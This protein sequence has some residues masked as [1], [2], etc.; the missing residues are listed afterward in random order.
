ME[1]LKSEDF[2][3]EGVNH[4]N[5]KWS[6]RKSISESHVNTYYLASQLRS[7]LKRYYYRYYGRWG[8]LNIKELNKDDR[9]EEVASGSNKAKDVW[10]SV[11]TH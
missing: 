1:R 9:E 7:Q 10:K 6:W 11:Q 4:W 8:I 2:Q 3:Q 5:K